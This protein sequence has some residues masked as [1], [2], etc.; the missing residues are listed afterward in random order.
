MG[1][2]E[3][4][5]D[6][7]ELSV[8]DLMTYHERPPVITHPSPD[9][10]IHYVEDDDEAQGKTLTKRKR[11][12]KIEKLALGLFGIPAGSPGGH[13][14]FRKRIKYEQQDK[15]V[16]EKFF[17]AESNIETEE[18]RPPVNI[19]R[20]HKRKPINIPSKTE[21]EDYFSFLYSEDG[22]LRRRRIPKLGA[23]MNTEQRELNKLSKAL[24]LSGHIKQSNIVRDLALG[25]FVKTAFDWDTDVKDII[26]R[27]AG[28]AGIKA[29]QA[30]WH[31]KLEEAV[32]GG[33][34]AEVLAALT[35]DQSYW[36]RV[37]TGSV[38][39]FALDPA[40]LG[41][42]YWAGSTNAWNL[43]GPELRAFF[44]EMKKVVATLKP[45][46]MGVVERQA[47]RSGT[48]EI[49]HVPWLVP[50]SL[51]AEPFK[52][53]PKTGITPGAVALLALSDYS[54]WP[55][56]PGA[57]SGTL[58]FGQVINLPI[59]KT[60][61]VQ[62]KYKKKLKIFWEEDGKTVYF[63][64]GGKSMAAVELDEDVW[65]YGV[66]ETGEVGS[67]KPSKPP[68]AEGD[69]ADDHVVASSY[70]KNHIKTA[71]KKCPPGVTACTPKPAPKA[72]PATTPTVKTK[73]TGRRSQGVT[74]RG[75][76][77]GQVITTK[78]E[79]LRFREWANKTYDVARI[80]KDRG[81]TD[82][83]LDTGSNAS[84]TNNHIKTVW[85]VVGDQ[86]IAKVLK[87]T[88]G[89]GY[90]KAP[91]RKSYSLNPDEGLEVDT[92]AKESGG[93]AKTAPT[94][95]IL[96]AYLM[97]P[98]DTTKYAN[99]ENLKVG[100]ITFPL[101]EDAETKIVTHLDYFLTRAKAQTIKAYE[102]DLAADK[103]GAIEKDLSYAAW[104]GEQKAA[105]AIKDAE[106]DKADRKETGVSQGN[107]KEYFLVPPHGEGGNFARNNEVG[108]LWI[109][110]ADPTKIFYIGMDGD[111]KALFPI[112]RRG[113][114]AGLEGV[115]GA[116]EWLD[117][118]SAKEI[119]SAVNEAG[120]RAGKLLKPVL[121]AHNKLED[122]TSGNRFLRPDKL[123]RSR[124]SKKKQEALDA[125]QTAMAQ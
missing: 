42:S 13:Q 87:G 88:G 14:G 109:T 9:N 62:E 68:A 55:E 12:E 60:K 37:G 110:K 2:D 16:A 82:T 4:S 104:V 79:G 66:S 117:Q 25:N 26:D 71:S 15:E 114:N 95:G 83:K 64:A 107:S 50:T 93:Q 20:L 51:G 29:P 85:Q 21:S 24:K 27:A 97:A 1:L 23:N 124:W 54:R 59:Q 33:K 91:S 92:E 48:A 119:A 53:V 108:T 57:D 70:R 78:E 118:L 105:K 30:G 67:Y 52:G 43:T 84:H 39:Q 72:K 102:A 80:L 100:P 113:S 6:E 3:P 74:A 103:T 28:F 61:Y 40:K 90:S 75:Y 69:K 121:Q 112:S 44:E 96:T 123:G 86:Y 58:P 120:P 77:L 98:A 32:G 36:K 94:D 47:E 111:K 18:S 122:Y 31:R 99:R 56:I 5:E 41:V 10:I 7:K 49:V 76:S 73:S 46:L 19:S 101:V 65:A 63:D 89:S 115:E 35:G 34:G 11:K 22:R 8:I 106:D 81:F 116:S 125:W 38:Q 45:L 17:G